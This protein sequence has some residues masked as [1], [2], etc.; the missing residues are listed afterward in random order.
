MAERKWT[1]EQLCAIETRDRTLLVSA[2]AGSGKTATLTERIIRSLTDKENP[3]E[4][5]SLLVVTFTNAAARELRAKISAALE[6]AVAA[7]PENAVLQRQLYMLPAA[8]IRTIDS[9]CNDILRANAD[10]V[11]IP[12]NYRIADT[13]ET[14]LLSK[15]IIEAL[16]EATYEGLEPDITSPEEFEALADCLTDSKRTEELYEV[17]A[18]VWDKCE[19]CE[20]G[21][22]ALVPLI[23]KYNPDSFASVEKTAH[24]SYLFAC[25]YEMLDHYSAVLSAAFRDFSS[26]VGREVDYAAVAA[27]DLALVNRLRQAEGYEGVRAI[28]LDAKFDKMPS[29][30]AADKTPRMED[31][32]IIRNILKSDIADFAAYFRY[33]TEQ[34]RELFS[35]LYKLL[36]VL[37]RF[38]VR[39]DRLFLEEKIRRGALSYGDIERQAYRCLV[40]NGERTDIAKNLEKQFA[41]IYID[42][43]QDV[44]SLQNEIF[45]AIS[46][47]DN[48]FM[49]GDIKQSIYGF[50]SARPAIFADMKSS[51]PPL[52]EKYTE[53]ASIFMSKNFRCDKGVVDFVNGVFDRVFSLIGDSI[54]YAPGDRL[55]YAKIHDGGEPEY[56]RPEICMIDKDAEI[57]EP[58]VVAKKIAELLRAGT[59]DSGEA[60]RPCDVAIIMRYATGKDHLYAEA[61]RELGI[62]SKISGAKDFFLSPEILLAMCLLNSIDN[63]HRDIYLAGLMCSP[64]F[65][66]DADDLYRIREEGGEGE[67]YEALCAYTEAHPEF[68]K[69]RDFLRSLTHYRAIAEGVGVST[70]LHR[71]YYETG[72]MALAAANGGKEN[73]LVLYDYARNY[74]A[75]AFKGLYNFIH[76]VNELIDK[77]TTFDD[78]REG[79][80]EDAVKIVTCHASKGLEYPVVFLVEAGKTFTNR[81]ARGRLVIDEDFGISFR[82]RSPS[83]LA[84]VNSPVQDLVNHYVY[85]KSFEEE[86]RV[87]Y[88]AL[89]RAREQL[90]VTG[91]CSTVKREEY[92]KKLSVLRDTLSPYSVRELAST[93]EI[94][95]VAGES[96]RAL[97]VEDFLPKVVE[98]VENFEDFA[99]AFDENASTATENT[100]IPCEFN[101]DTDKKL[102]GLV[103]EGEGY[104]GEDELVRRFTFEYPYKYITDLP[105]KMSVSRTSPTVLDGA[106]EGV[107]LFEEP[108][109]ERVRVLPKFAEG[110]PY[111]ESARRGIATHYFMQFCDLD[112]LA[113]SGAQAEL[114]RLVERGF[115]SQADGERVRIGEIEK[116][117]RSRLFAE[118]R[119]AKRVWREFRFNTHFDATLFTSEPER[120]KAYSGQQVLVQG[121]IDCI[122]EFSDG[123]LGL[124]DYKTDRLTNEQLADVK[125]AEAVM[126]ERHEQQLYFYSLAIERIF[127][128]RPKV[129]EVYSLPLGDS[130]SVRKE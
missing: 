22:D 71:L 67:L 70:L 59:L 4:I 54:G 23:E 82:L 96:S 33:T 83:G 88:V 99:S 111:E 36:S 77:D 26:G 37:Y 103:L 114:A 66:F 51:F 5:G 81:D 53:A 118:M 106:E 43:Y 18:L 58:Q 128:K 2:A 125:L 28:I 68:E 21:I 46:R 32:V 75:G 115:I 30:K 56:R 57:T 98:R 29:V 24:G 72:L 19:S 40:A 112:N 47:P 78:N 130:V 42:E 109:E 9:F 73:L 61:L 85:R 92:D 108:E 86:L 122:V 65:S 50:R 90:Y 62:P 8:K 117:R 121:V 80:E 44:N 87:L 119:G 95:M 126:R 3:V 63:P 116:F 34:W 27:S 60:I 124:Y 45:A 20:S 104:V 31:Y 69:G 14:A 38:E 91:V 110:R 12:A 48:R 89:T 101:F 15:S 11:G 1:E 107:I 100:P 84:V 41:A 74:E 49:V 93:L 17:L 102:R 105:E 13:A 39:F 97:S 10:R 120:Q 76:F 6:R 55:G 7:D 127:G 16:V 64:L 52:G 129:V 123:S 94:M 25:L 79:G 35:S 113:E